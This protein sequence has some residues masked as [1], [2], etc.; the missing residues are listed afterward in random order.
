M[1]L[2]KG[3]FFD[4][5]RSSRINITYQLVYK[6]VVLKNQPVQLQTKHLFN[7]FKNQVTDVIN[8]C[9]IMG[10]TA[11]YHVVIVLFMM[12][13]A[14]CNGKPAA[15][16]TEK[17][18]IAEEEI[19]MNDKETTGES[20]NTATSIRYLFTCYILCIT[21]ILSYNR[22]KRSSCQS[23]VFYG[24]SGGI[25]F[26]DSCTIAGI[27]KIEIWY[28]K[29]IH[30]IKTTYI[31]HTGTTSAVFHGATKNKNKSYSKAT[32]N[33]LYGEKIIGVVGQYG[34]YTYIPNIFVIKSLAFLTETHYGAR[35]VYGPYG[36]SGTNTFI[37]NRD[38]T[39]FFGRAGGAI[40]SIGFYYSN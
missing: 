18:A 7:K 36:G 24:G 21:L 5:W 29:D 15:K 4:Q 28:D 22:S 19:D 8:W 9:N 11:K 30:G 38:V 23:T 10:V 3:P 2:H 6:G 32:I 34:K 16:E 37:I 12:T 39:A 17:I 26:Y 14:V 25:A 31:T 20:F 35:R 1:N 13:L 27:K 40:D 33:L